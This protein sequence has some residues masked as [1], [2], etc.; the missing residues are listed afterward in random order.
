MNSQL[1]RITN[2]LVRKF[3]PERVIPFGSRVRGLA[4]RDSDYDLLVVMPFK[5]R[6]RDIELQMRLCVHDINVAKEI[7]LN[8]PEDLARYR[9]VPGTIAREAMRD[10]REVY[11]RGR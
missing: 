4:R 7:V 1:V 2:R 8:S 9:S 11:A 3:D 5:G 6:R 10:G